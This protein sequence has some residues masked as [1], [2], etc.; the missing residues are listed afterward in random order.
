M[1]VEAHGSGVS[2][3]C[4]GRSRQTHI[5][6]GGGVA[7]K[8]RRRQQEATCSAMSSLRKACR[9]L[10][11]GGLCQALQQRRPSHPARA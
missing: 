11:G 10:Q 6:G 8:S 2:L 5:D 4:R 9:V 3:S 7:H 1:Q